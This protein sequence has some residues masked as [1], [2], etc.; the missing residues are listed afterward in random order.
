MIYKNHSKHQ[1]PQPNSC[2]PVI[3]IS[4]SNNQTQFMK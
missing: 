3:S 4:S 1:A 2:Y